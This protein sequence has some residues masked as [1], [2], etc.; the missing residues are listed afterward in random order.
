MRFLVFVGICFLL[1]LPLISATS[2][3]SVTTNGV[4]QDYKAENIYVVAPDSIHFGEEFSIIVGIEINTS[5]SKTRNFYL[6]GSS[7][8]PVI[9]GV[10][11]PKGKTFAI[12]EWNITPWNNQEFVLRGVMNNA[13]FFRKEIH[14]NLKNKVVIN[15]K[16]LSSN[17]VDLA[18]TQDN[19]TITKARVALAKK[20]SQYSPIEFDQMI[21]LAKESHDL[22]KRVD[23]V[24]ET[25]ED[26]TSKVKTI[27]TISVSSKEAY[28]NSSVDVIEVIPKDTIS[29]AKMI[30]L[31]PSSFVLKE[32]PII[33]W[34]VTG[35]KKNITYEIEKDVA[36]TGNTIMVSSLS[37]DKKS[38]QIFPWRI[39]GP[40]LVIPII[41]GIIVFFARFEPKST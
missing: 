28:K 16:L 11:T 35:V 14:L 27:V 17:F 31:S 20:N 19:A 30:K 34:H 15:S 37:A 8:D 2:Y 36:V 39:I 18:T 38:G 25:Y 6:D 9:S 41:A 23:K 29:D 24:L 22:T 4:L 32:D 13:E 40:L 12:Y 7:Q 33:M 3:D 1:L 10:D 26:N 5:I 21:K